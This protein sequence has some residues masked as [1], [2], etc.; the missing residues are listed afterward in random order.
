MSKEGDG[1]PFSPLTLSVRP[2]CELSNKK[3]KK[4]NDN[5]NPNNDNNNN[6]NNFYY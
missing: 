2:L 4:N 3:K 1:A 5:D 6:N